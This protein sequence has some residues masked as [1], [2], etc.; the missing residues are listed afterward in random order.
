VDGGFIGSK[1]S[2][3]IWKQ[4][5]KTKEGICTIVVV[6]EGAMKN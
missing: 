6:E 4:E 3:P 5:L 1:E 2:G